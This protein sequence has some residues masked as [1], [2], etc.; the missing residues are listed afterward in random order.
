M[1]KQKDTTVLYQPLQ[2]G[3]KTRHISLIALGGIIGSSYF[4]GTGYLLNQVGPCAFLAYILG[5][6]IS[7]LTLACL[8]ELA[9][10]SPSQGSFV[11]A[12]AMHISPSWAC[13]VGWSYWFCWIIYIPS[14]CIGGALIMNYFVP[15][16]P[17]AIWALF[18]G[19]IITLCNVMTVK[20]FGEAEFWLALLKI[21]LL[22]GFCVIGLLILLGWVGVPGYSY[23]AIQP[24]SS[25]KNIFPNGI[26]I[27]FINMLILMANFQGSEIIGLTATESENPKKAVPKALKNVSLRIIGL[28][29]IPTLLL[30]LLLPWKEAGL[31]QNAF[32]AALH[33]Y[34]LS[35]L[36]SIFSF[37]IITGA[38]SSSNGGL[39][40]T[41]RTLFSLA[42]RG[43]A[44][45]AL[46]KVSSHGIPVYATVYTLCAVWLILLLS[47]FGSLDSVYALLL[48][49]SGFTGSIC[50]ISICWS[51]LIFRKHFKE[52]GVSL[53]YKVPLFPYLTHF[54]IWLQVFLLFVVLFY[55][56][57]RAS[58]YIGMPVLILPILIYKKFCSHDPKMVAKL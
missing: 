28:Y 24:F 45:K 11:H 43:M 36:A 7:Y 29:I 26:S 51:Q 39:Y 57:T 5:G 41:I 25:F 31:D 32:S 10:S 20:I 55:P 46:T 54:A 58:F 12:A 48:A 4:L 53:T 2:R 33:K 6:L 22:I 19:L 14:E 17:Q 38:I 21:I 8:A 3:L 37:V 35:N 42:Q 18:F 13:G 30:S 52:T 9:V 50:W 44:P 15:E 40:A 47:I 34:G 23:S 56:N 49:T 1:E 16:V 27:L